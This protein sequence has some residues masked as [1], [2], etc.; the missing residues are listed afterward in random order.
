VK[1]KLHTDEGQW[2]IRTAHLS[3]SGLKDF[4]VQVKSRIIDES[5]IHV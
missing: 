5:N 2:E 1:K 3:S 4:N